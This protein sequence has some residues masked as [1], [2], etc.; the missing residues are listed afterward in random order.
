MRFNE[1]ID[2]SWAIKKLQDVVSIHARIGWQGLRQ[3]E[4]LDTGEIYLITGT[5]FKNGI[6]DYSNCKYIDKDRYELDKNIQVSNGDILIT[7]DGS[8][9]KIAFVEKLT[10]PAT[11]NAGVYRVRAKDNSIRSKYLFHYLDGPFL[12][13]YAAKN[14]TGGTIQH[15]NQSSIINL[16]VPIPN[17]KIQNKISCFLDLVDK[18]IETQIKIIEDLEALNIELKRAQFNKIKMNVPNNLFSDIFNEYKEFNSR[19]LTQYTIGKKGIVSLDSELNYNTDKHIV[20]H[21][22]T[23]ILG[24][25][26]DEIGVSRDIEGCCS[27]IYKTYNINHSIA[28][29]DYIYHFSRMYFDS[30]KRFVTQKSTRREY[31]FDYKALK[32]MKMYIPSIEEQ[33]KLVNLF[34]SFESKIKKEKDILKCYESQKVYLLRNLFI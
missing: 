11:L 9:G 12:M 1:D 15:L 30:I 18:R 10:I 2:K 5:D 4:F 14:S 32:K 29:L 33:S 8:I 13:D 16:P 20:F 27:P 25:G 6:I 21:P 22:G 17:L 34:N 23:C 31:E 19:E 26:I 7:K 28:M 24:I 3:S